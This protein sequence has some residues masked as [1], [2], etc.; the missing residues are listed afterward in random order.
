MLVAPGTAQGV[1]LDKAE[2]D[3]LILAALDQGSVKDAAA[4]LVERTGLPRRELYNR[5][6]KLRAGVGKD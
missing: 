5:A 1:A 3:A 4:A 2:I 6:V